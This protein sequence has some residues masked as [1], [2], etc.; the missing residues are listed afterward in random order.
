MEEPDEKTSQKIRKVR[1]YCL[2]A[3]MI[4]IPAQ[5]WYFIG[6][7]SRIS[8]LILA[9]LYFVF[10]GLLFANKKGWLDGRG[11]EGGGDGGGDGGCGGG[12]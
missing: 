11:G 5:I 8:W 4:I 9:F 1:V 10:G 7:D 12:E 6:F 3:A 2:S